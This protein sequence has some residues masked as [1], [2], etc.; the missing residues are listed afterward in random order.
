ML[1]RNP[2]TAIGQTSFLQ[3][4][5]EKSPKPYLKLPLPV[6]PA[7][8]LSELAQD[9]TFFTPAILYLYAGMNDAPL[10]DMSNEYGTPIPIFYHFRDCAPFYTGLRRPDG[11]RD[12]EH[13]VWAVRAA[14]AANV[15]SFL[16]SLVFR[17]Q[18]SS[19]AVMVG[20]TKLISTDAD[21]SGASA[22]DSAF[23]VE[24][25]GVRTS[26][27]CLAI[28]PWGPDRLHEMRAFPGDSFCA[29]AGAALAKEEN[30]L[31]A[32]DPH[33]GESGGQSHVAGN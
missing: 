8:K 10:H 15:L 6:G 18:N 13:C 22:P 25:Y 17:L 20:R 7:G 21:R 31:R 14:D 3:A 32:P 11:S 23:E 2:R 1:L 9:F 16:D 5:T 29:F 28:V 26:R 12:W 30:F 24:A 19:E 27:G 33:P 4:E